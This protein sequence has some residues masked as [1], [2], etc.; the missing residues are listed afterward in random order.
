MK[1]AACTG[2]PRSMCL[3]GLLAPHC[4]DARPDIPRLGLRVPVS[5]GRKENR[6]QCSLS[7]Q[8]GTRHGDIVRAQV[9]AMSG[10]E[11]SLCPLPHGIFVILKGEIVVFIFF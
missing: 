2:V 9:L 7:A 11:R 6:Q 1:R 8:A 4:C 10:H 3:S 5:P